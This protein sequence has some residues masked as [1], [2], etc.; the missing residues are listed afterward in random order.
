ML[1]T[2]GDEEEEEDGE[3]EEEEGGDDKH[4]L[5]NGL[6]NGPLPSCARSDRSGLPINLPAAA[7]L[8]SIFCTTSC[9][10]LI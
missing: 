9:F 5:A 6:D 3:E 4:R 2:R 10:D 1:T 7:V 8:D